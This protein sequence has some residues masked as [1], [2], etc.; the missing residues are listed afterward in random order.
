VYRQPISQTMAALGKSAGVEARSYAADRIA[1]PELGFMFAQSHKLPD[2]TP[3]KP[4][5]A[6]SPYLPRPGV[7]VLDGLVDLDGPFEVKR[8]L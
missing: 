2:F 5:L 6:R 1:E 4:V 7:H 3:R 8:R